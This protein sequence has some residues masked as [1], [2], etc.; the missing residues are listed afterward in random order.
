MWV[1]HGGAQ[2][3]GGASGDLTAAGELTALLGTYGALVQLVLMARSPWLERTFGLDGLAHWHRRNGF[4]TVILIIGHVVFTT[5]GY[6]LGDGQSLAGE[7]LALL[8]T[9]P[10]VL[11]AAAA[12][13][14]LVMV[15]VTSMRA[16]RRRLKH[17]TWLFLH[18]YVYLA[19][20]L[21]FGHELAVGFDFSNDN[22]A[23]AYWIALYAVAFGLI[24]SFR[25]GHPIL[26]A[27]RHELRVLAV[28]P[29]ADGVA[30]VYIGGRDLDQLNARAGQ[31]FLWRFLARDRWWQANPFSLSAAPQ[32]EQLRITVKAVGE[33]SGDVHLLTPGT[34]VFVD[35]PFGRFTLPRTR[36]PILF[37]AGGIGITPIRA[38]L[39]ELPPGRSRKVVIY[40]ARR[41]ED[42]A[43]VAELKQL[44]ESRRADLH[45]IVGDPN[46]SQLPFEPL[47]AGRL[48]RLVPDIRQRDIFVCGPVGMMDVVRQ[49]LDKLRIPDRQVHYETFALL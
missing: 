10:Y 47:S 42:L 21:A 33:G 39:E 34:R 7:M 1:R 11:M 9:Y 14:L 19:I 37:I 2:V 20:V 15:A 26:L 27:L 16:I 24:L 46:S 49:S 44:A 25:L 29:E 41:V 8:T 32:Q 22:L 43:L 31:Y 40:R 13:G 17:E 28:V 35:G 36:R 38:L 12:T 5:A 45:V 6:A 48:Q 18:V 23:R 30:S 3:L 4:A